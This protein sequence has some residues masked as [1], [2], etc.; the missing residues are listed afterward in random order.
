M[1]GGVRT[2]SVKGKTGSGNPPPQPA[3]VLPGKG[4]AHDSW[5]GGPRKT[6]S[7]GESKVG[8]ASGQWSRPQNSIVSACHAEQEAPGKS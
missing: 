2:V 8:T 4:A 3:V 7:R 5:A 1:I 6:G